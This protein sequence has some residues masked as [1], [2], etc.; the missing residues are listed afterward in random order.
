M[1]LYTY[2]RVAEKIQPA[3]GRRLEQESGSRR[4]RG[5]ARS[6]ADPFSAFA[7]LLRGQIVPE[8]GQIDNVPVGTKFF[9]KRL[10][11]VPMMG[12]VYPWISPTTF[13]STIRS[14]GAPPSG[15]RTLRSTRQSGISPCWRNCATC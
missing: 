1:Y 7:A 4:E 14:P 11:F 13:R 9:A 15:R 6:I 2:V 5:R 12:K 8:S 3:L 10:T